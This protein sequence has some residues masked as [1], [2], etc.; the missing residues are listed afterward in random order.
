[1]QAI[2]AKPEARKL[3]AVFRMS[4]RN[5]D[6]YPYPGI[7]EQLHPIFA[8]LAKVE[9]IHERMNP[10]LQGQCVDVWWVPLNEGII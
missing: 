5:L 3:R 7:N 4:S 10:W 8:T 6:K 9:I 2:P 1:M